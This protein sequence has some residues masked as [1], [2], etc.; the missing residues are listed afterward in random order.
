MTRTCS[1][2]LILGLA[3]IAL[4][5]ACTD[6]PTVAPRSIRPE[7]PARDV[8][9]SGGVTYLLSAEVH[10]TDLGQ[11][12][13]YD[14]PMEGVAGS[15]AS[16]PLPIGGTRD[17]IL[18]AHNQYGEVTHQGEFLAGKL[19]V[20]PNAP[21]TVAL[22]PVGGIGRQLTVTM[23]IVGEAPVSGL[24]RVVVQPRT[25]A[26]LEGQEM[27]VDAYAFDVFGNRMRISPSQ[28]HWAVSDPRSGRMIPHDAQESFLAVST[29]FPTSV[30]AIIGNHL[31]SFNPTLTPDPFIDI[32]AGG[33]HN[34]ALRQSGTLFCWGSNNYGEL[35]SA[36]NHTCG[37]SVQWCQTRPTPVSGGKLWRSVSSGNQHTCAIDS[38]H[39]AFCWGDS[40]MD[41]LGSSSSNWTGANPTPLAVDGG[42][43][44]DVITSGTQHS[45]AIESVTRVSYCWGYQY[46]GALG[47]GQGTGQGSFPTLVFGSHPFT[48]INAGNQFTCA[49]DTNSDTWCWGANNN[50]ELGHQSATLN[51]TGASRDSIPRLTD[52]TLKAVALSKGDGQTT[53][54]V[55]SSGSSFCWGLNTDGVTGTGSTSATV[56]TPTLL[57][58][59]L[60]F[61]SIA[62]GYDHSCGIANG[63]VLCWGT[64][65]AGQLG[66]LT[67]APHSS[68]MP[69]STKWSF[70]KV[71]TGGSHTCGIA[72]SGSVFCWGEGGLGMLGNGTMNVNSS[73]PVKVAP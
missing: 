35:G 49:V 6:D 46:M 50:F 54:F 48:Q 25:D 4:A 15:G 56:A 12:F 62:S 26:V 73:V 55:A 10:S 60:A 59:N 51:F 38:G 20:G 1:N 7:M 31:G 69:V 5:A 2:R 61:S 13:Y 45:C 21:V 57:Q 22:S 67:T 30:I 19:A 23:D 65:W 39:S 14:I 47:N 37:S 70:T 58:G 8:S 32:S 18:R 16:L 52:N 71:S 64:N 33:N 9:V 44:Y 40:N 24:A 66:D 72:V 42:R 17:V 27:Y 34:C 63:Q 36:L 29:G 11:V 3:I 28:I 41:E 43:L 53:C 68:P